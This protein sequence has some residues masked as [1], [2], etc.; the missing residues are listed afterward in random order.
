MAPAFDHFRDRDAEG[1]CSARLDSEPASCKDLS[2][3]CAGHP[4]LRNDPIGALPAELQN[5][6]AVEIVLSFSAQVKPNCMPA[7]PHGLQNFESLA[8]FVSPVQ[9]GR[10]SQTLV[11]FPPMGHRGNSVQ[12]DGYITAAQSTPQCCFTRAAVHREL[13]ITRSSRSTFRPDGLP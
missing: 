9:Y 8:L 3:V 6:P 7:L 10:S 12:T 13:A 4:P 2:F 11:P 1:L 5:A